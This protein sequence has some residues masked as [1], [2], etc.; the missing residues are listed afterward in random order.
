[1]ALGN[2]K[3]AGSEYDSIQIPFFSILANNV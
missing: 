1:M 3:K 2:N